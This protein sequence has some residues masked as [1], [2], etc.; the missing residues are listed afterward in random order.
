[1]VLVLALGTGL[2]SAMFA[3]ADPFLWR[4][5]PFRD[6]HR[7]VVLAIDNR[8]LRQGAIVPTLDDWRRRADLFEDVAATG[9]QSTLRLGRESGAIALTT[10]AATGDLFDVLGIRTGWTNQWRDETQPDTS[11]LALLPRRSDAAAEARVSIGSTLP[12]QGGGRARFVG[13]LPSWFVIPT[14]RFTRFEPPDALVRISDGP[15]ATVTRWRNDGR[16][17]ASSGLNV[18]ARVRSG[19]TPAA[20]EA[21]LAVPVPSAPPAGV[22]ATPLQDLMKARL[23]PLALGA[24]GAGLLILLISAANIAN[25]M[26]ARGVFRERELATRLALGATR[27]DLVRLVLTE[28]VLMAAAGGAA[29]LGIAAVALAVA[30][31]SMPVQYAALGA[32]AV[33][34]RV[35][36]FAA[37]AAAVVMATDC[38]RPWRSGASP[39]GRS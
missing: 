23:R 27:W 34:L 36:A 7:L 2:T 15:I 13:E 26:V 16:P 28:L 25:L 24:L 30:Q 33:T 31:H 5:L 22:T 18:V 1:M 9:E 39:H 38:W 12:I 8:A 37:A 20:L 11:S 19:V 35:A 17:S 21:A 32:P 6:P 4:A 10:L 3:L 29:G 14:D